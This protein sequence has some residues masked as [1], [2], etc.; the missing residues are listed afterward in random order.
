[1]L[2]VDCETCGLVGVIC[3]IQYAKD[4]G[5]I[6]LYSPWDRPVQET[7]DLIE[8]FTRDDFCGFNIVFDWFHLQKL[9]CMLTLI[10]DKTK[11]PSIEEMAAI[12]RQAIHVDICIKPKRACDLMLVARKGKYQMIMNRKPINI[13]KVPRALAFELAKELETRVQI[14]GI[15]F[16]SR[17]DK[18]APRWTVRPNKDDD[19]FMDV[20]LKFNPKG[21]LKT[22]ASFA[23]GAEEVLKFEDIQLDDHP[24]EVEYAPY[25]EATINAPKQKK[26]K[27][28]KGTQPWPQIVH[29]HISHWLYNAPARKYAEKDIVYTR[30][31]WEHLGR[32]EPGDDDSELAVHVAS[33]RW[34]G[35]AIDV[36][37]M[38]RLREDAISRMGS[39]PRSAAKAKV[40]IGQAMT[41]DER[42]MFKST[43][44][45]E[46]ETIIREWKAD[47]GVSPHPAALR[48][49]EVNNARKAEK[50]RELFDKLIHALRAHPDF[51][52]IGAKSSRMSGAGGVNFQGINRQKKVRR[53]FTFADEGELL[54]GGDFDAF[55][56][57]ILDA[58]YPDKE[59]HKLLQTKRP[60]VH[61]DATGRRLKD[62]ELVKC[63]E[64]GGDGEVL[65]KIHALFAMQLW[66]HLT[67]DEIMLTKGK[68]PDLYTYGKNTVFSQAYD[69]TADTIVRKI[70]GATMEQAEKAAQSW[71][72]KFPEMATGVSVVRDT[73][74]A[75]KQPGG[76]GTQVF[77]STPPDTADTMLGFS[78]FFMLENQIAKSLYDLAVAPPKHW[79]DVKVKVVRRERVQ[80]ASGATNSALYGAAFAVQ[81]AVTRQAL[82]HVIQG[83]GS[84][85]CKATQRAI[86]DLQPA[87]VNPWLVRTLNCHDEILCVTKPGHESVIQTT[88]NRTVESFRPIVPLIA[89]KIGPMESWASK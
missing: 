20:G 67:Y 1:M 40:Y 21:D 50:E 77:W 42:Q 83:T 68:D 44:K 32:P 81:G 25:W 58:R 33:A 62:D 26:S 18:Y 30:A 45:V 9:F 59:L 72:R 11:K 64:C 80:T 75:M 66:P 41:P 82:N 86:C 52:I 3:L 12:E 71:Q 4:D 54:V 87:G 88:V 27:R 35:F 31:L 23:L 19:A 85:I 51:R 24:L 53:C 48:A 16:A 39:A 47:D 37:R 14:P 73:Y 84:G 61:C 8:S 38:K 78:R 56:V 5:P 34:R 76:L 36:E 60:C 7:L 63:S 65:T 15:M 29:R 22:L 79:K 28:K 17:K 2:Y 74:K 13:K 89:F 69:G 46:L 70:P 6:T 57:C 10:K 55:E 43:K 49:K